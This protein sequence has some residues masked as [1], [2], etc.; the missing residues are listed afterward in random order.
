MDGGNAGLFVKKG[1][2]EGR[3]RLSYGM[4]KGID[5][6]PRNAVTGKIETGPMRRE[7]KRR[8]EKKGSKPSKRIRFFWASNFTHTTG[9][10]ATS[11]LYQSLSI[12]TGRTD[13]TVNSMSRSLTPIDINS[14]H[15]NLTRAVIF[16]EGSKR[17]M[18]GREGGRN[19]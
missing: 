12:H 5:A 16:A 18:N 8:R 14:S 15:L 1:V 2:R 9:T 10:P 6:E 19:G 7:S 11:S 3:V 17:G 4:P 13:L